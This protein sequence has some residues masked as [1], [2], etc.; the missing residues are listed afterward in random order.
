[1]P[2]KQ[3]HIT[4]RLEPYQE[5]SSGTLKLTDV[6]PALGSALQTVAIGPDV[7]IAEAAIDCEG[8]EDDVELANLLMEVLDTLQ[9]YAP[10]Y[11][12]VGTHEGDGALYGVWPCVDSLLYDIQCGEVLGVND[13]SE[14]P[15]DHCGAVAIIN[16]RGSVKFGHAVAGEFFELWSVI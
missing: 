8:C 10:D 2:N 3:E 16:E 5:F 11:C 12:Y 9:E 1:M 14:I 4:E 7:K 6:L 15:S 13:G